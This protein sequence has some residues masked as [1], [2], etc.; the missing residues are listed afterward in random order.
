M[1]AVLIALGLLLVSFEAQAISRY[2]STSMSC[3]RVRAVVRSEGAV[4][5]RWTGKSGAPRY[6]RFV[7]HGGFCESGTR[8][9]TSY[10]PAA[11]RRCPVYECKYWD[12]DDLLI[13]RG[14]RWD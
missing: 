4:I 8:A 6:G 14:G 13:F 9:Q 1:K 11:D 3:E 5:L 10:V 2:N 7:A 12:P